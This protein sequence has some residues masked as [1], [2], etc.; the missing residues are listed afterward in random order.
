MTD[1]LLTR[2][3]A[4]VAEERD[5][6]V[7]EIEG[8]WPDLD[9]TLYRIGPNPQFDPIPPYNPLQGDG[10]VHAFR[11]GG[12][13]I[14]YTNR[15]VRTMRFERE[16]AAGRALFATSG[17]PRAHDPSVATLA[18]DGAAN[19]NVVAHAGRLLA[20]EEG[21][22]PLELDGAN[23]ATRGPWTFGG[24]LASSFTAHPKY[25]PATGELVSFSNEPGRRFDGTVHWHVTDRRGVLRT[26]GRLTL[27]WSSPIHDFV[28]TRE[29]VAFIVCP[30]TISMKRARDGGSAVAYQPNLGTRIAVV[31]RSGGEPVWFE[32]PPRQVWHVL[33]AWNDGAR[34]TVDVC[35]QAAPALPLEDGSPTD[36]IGHRQF[37][38]RWV[39]DAHRPG[40]VAIRR[41]ADAVCEYP[42]IDER[43][44]MVATRHGYVA[45]EGGPG[46]G[47]LFHRGIGRFDF[48]RE[49]FASWSFGAG[50]AVAEP[51][52]IPR[53]VGTGEG[54]LLS[55]EYDEVHDT[56]ALVCFDAG[57][58]ESGPIASA[59]L[60]C[61]VPMGFH[62]CWVEA[63]GSR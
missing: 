12:G 10:M 17:D 44:A 27:P 63:R 1:P 37:L 58:L 32:A 7:L 40:A 22:V 14:S 35:E 47:D 57:T 6:A 34:I 2:G 31:P 29:F 23:L 30:V 36:P 56:S 13:G 18:T 49:R 41:L 11:M 5:I 55:V 4:P 46:T 33:N 3:F 42:R 28:V 59:R 39:F 48:A 54:W 51:V 50:K 26:V 24:Q 38:T 9:G 62:G 61:R 25:D 15:W 52:F 16:R 21:H 19:T 60:A 53:A 8:D 43:F 45:C 20:L